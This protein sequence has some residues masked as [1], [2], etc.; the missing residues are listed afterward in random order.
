M[1][2]SHPTRYIGFS[3]M[4]ILQTSQSMFEIDVSK[5]KACY[6]NCHR[7]RTKPSF[8][9]GFIEIVEIDSTPPV[10]RLCY[11]IHEITPPMVERVVQ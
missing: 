6:D 4:L 11:K 1:T 8:R 7:R 2:I 10:L 5:D 3:K 9:K